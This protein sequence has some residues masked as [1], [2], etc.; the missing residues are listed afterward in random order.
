MKKP[1]K[2]ETTPP[3]G[4]LVAL[5]PE[6]PAAPTAE[7]CGATKGDRACTLAAGHAGYHHSMPK[8]RTIDALVSWA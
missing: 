6:L 4:T 7:T 2:D 3:L 8:E 5:P 1:P